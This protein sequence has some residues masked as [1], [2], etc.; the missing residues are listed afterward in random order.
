MCEIITHFIVIC[1]LFSKFAN[2]RMLPV[3]NSSVLS[4]SSLLGEI[5][6]A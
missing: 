1:G 5:H 6:A 3:V 2:I 4:Q